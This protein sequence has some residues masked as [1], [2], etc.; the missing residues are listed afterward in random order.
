MAELEK[1]RIASDVTVEISITA[2]GQP[3]DLRSAEEMA[4][5]AVGRRQGACVPM[6]CAVK[7]SDPTKILAVFPASRQ[8]SLGDYEVVVR[9]R[10]GGTD[11]T[12][13]HPAF[14]LVPSTELS[15]VM[16][17]IVG[18]K[19]ESGVKVLSSDEVEKIAEKAE[20]SEKAAESSAAD[21]KASE[22]S[23]SASASEAQKSAEEAK[24]S[25]EYFDS[26]EFKEAVKGEKGDQGEK[27]DT[28]ASGAHVDDLVIEQTI[29]NSETAV[30]SQ[31]AVTEA[32]EGIYAHKEGTAKDMVPSLYT[33]GNS[34]QNITKDGYHFSITNPQFPSVDS[35]IKGLELGHKYKGVIIVDEIGYVNVVLYS[36]TSTIVT[37]P[38]NA[39]FMSVNTPYVFDLDTSTSPTSDLRLCIYKGNKG[40]QMTYTLYLYDVT[41]IDEGIVNDYDWSADYK[42]G[43]ISLGGT[44]GVLAET[45]ADVAKLKEQSL[46]YFYGKSW[47]ALGDSLTAKGSGSWYLDYL[48]EYLH[49]S[50]VTNCGIGGT[51]VSGAGDTCFYQDVRV[52]SLSLD[53]DVVSI[54]GGTN[55]APW[56]TV[57]DSDFN[58]DNHDIDNFVGAYNV[59]ISKVLYKFLK[60]K[61]YYSDIDYSGV[62]QVT[63]VNEGFRLFLI[64][65]PQRHDSKSNNDKAYA[66]GEYVKRIAR[67]WGIPVIDSYAK[68]GLNA[69]TTSLFFNST[70]DHVHFNKEA[71]RHLAN[72]ILEGLS[73]NI[74]YV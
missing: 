21:A 52:N 56:T 50:K 3:V 29:G 12:Y 55:D 19:I 64:T 72:V 16:T 60:V 51:R 73:D 39:K 14:T 10:I 2:D 45:N 11:V 1:I 31:K 63:E 28:G 58:T 4:V 49:L 9:L 30:M 26:P 6:A 22:E 46:D 25:K 65:P 43:D 59:L 61:G 24:A 8:L 40:T 32:V 27:G 69:M 68:M 34:S 42:S 35:Y 23:A 17:S 13:D 66:F 38:Y 37:R 57:S 36:A 54:M 44:F 62:T 74:Y 15:D 70:A 53:S 41:G 48:E 5:M 7:P 71:H 67:M 20:A 18:V 47:S 33:E